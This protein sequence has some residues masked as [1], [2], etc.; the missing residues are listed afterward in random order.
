MYLCGNSIPFA[1]VFFLVHYFHSVYNTPCGAFIFVDFDSHLTKSNFYRTIRKVKIVCRN[2][3]SPFDVKFL[4][5]GE[6]KW[7]KKFRKRKLNWE[8]KEKLNYDLLQAKHSDEWIEMF[9]YRCSSWHCDRW[10]WLHKSGW[11]IGWY[12]WESVVFN[13]RSCFVKIDQIW[14]LEEE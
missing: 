13:E 9:W 1:L 10:N 8:R 7:T 2:S 5:L 12:Q 3:T 4:I 14:C 6:E 11:K